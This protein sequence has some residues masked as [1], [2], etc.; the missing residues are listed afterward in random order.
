MGDMTVIEAMKELKLIEK[1]MARNSDLIRQ[2]SSKLSTEKPRFDSEKAQ[3]EKVK[4]L[5]QANEDLAKTYYRLHASIN[6]TNIKTKV[7]LGGTEYT[8]HELLLY[9]RKLA[10]MIADS[11]RSMDDHA[12][13]SQLRTAGDGVTVDRLYNEDF[14]NEKLEFWVD[15][16]ETI[17]GRLETVNATTALVPLDSI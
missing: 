12:A 2:Y 7:M 13:R 5:A 9:R 14:K 3:E 8:I 4:S 6:V 1:K 11:Y 15:L 10:S 16:R 17:D